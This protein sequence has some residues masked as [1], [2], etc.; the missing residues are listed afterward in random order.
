MPRAAARVTTGRP[1][2]GAPPPSAR[3]FVPSR[4]ATAAPRRG[5][6]TRHVG[7]GSV[8][9]RWCD[10][11]VPRRWL[12]CM[13]ALLMVACSVCHC[14]VCLSWHTEQA[15]GDFGLVD[16]ADYVLTSR[17]IGNYHEEVGRT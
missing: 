11:L 9:P 6:D 4:A 1:C 5:P 14:S 10:C 13:T 17:V 2:G 7:D 3:V 8:R 12:P 16:C 15:T